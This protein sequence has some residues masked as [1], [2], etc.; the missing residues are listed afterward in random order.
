[1]AQLVKYWLHKPEELRTPTWKQSRTVCAC[2]PSTGECS[3]RGILGLLLA[4]RDRSVSS[5]LCARYCFK[6]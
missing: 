1:M 4:S 3:S 5:R 2:N 6:N